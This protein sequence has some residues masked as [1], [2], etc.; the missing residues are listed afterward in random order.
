MEIYRFRSCIKDVLTIRAT[1]LE[2]SELVERQHIC[3]VVL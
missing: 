3:Q 2:A 1:L